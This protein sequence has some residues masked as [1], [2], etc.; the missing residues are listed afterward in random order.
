MIGR[1]GVLYRNL[2]CWS[3]RWRDNGEEEVVLCGIEALT[4]MLVDC[5]GLG[6]RGGG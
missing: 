2:S 4:R 6:G 5:R 3:P 1:K